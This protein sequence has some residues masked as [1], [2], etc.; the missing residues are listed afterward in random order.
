MS[1]A[2]NLW[3][4]RLRADFRAN[5]LIF[6]SSYTMTLTPVSGS[7]ADYRGTHELPALFGGTYRYAAHISGDRFTARYDSSYDHG[8]FDLARVRP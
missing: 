3:S 2:R 5:W 4:N 7:P 8:T 1:D 6:A